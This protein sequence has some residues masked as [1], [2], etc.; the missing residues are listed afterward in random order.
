MTFAVVCNI[1]DITSKTGTVLDR[2]TRG[3]SLISSRFLD[4]VLIVTIVENPDSHRH[5]VG[6]WNQKLHRPGYSSRINLGQRAPKV[7]Y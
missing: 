4:F 1:G 3:S 6:E 5:A 2:A 7:R